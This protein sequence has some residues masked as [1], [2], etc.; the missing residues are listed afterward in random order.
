MMETEVVFRLLIFDNAIAVAVT[1]MME[2]EVIC[3]MLVF[4]ST[5][6]WL[7]PERIL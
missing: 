7:S 4:G 2:I 5:L 6:T 1:L 3:E